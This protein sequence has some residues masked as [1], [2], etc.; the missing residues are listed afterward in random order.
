MKTN[1]ILAALL[2]TTLCAQGADVKEGIYEYDVIS[3]TAV[4]LTKVSLALDKDTVKL[5]VPQTVMLQH[6]EL[7]VTTIGQRAFE[8]LAADSIILPSSITT[9][10]GWAFQNSRKLT[11][12]NL[13]AALEE[14]PA[15]CFAGCTKLSKIV[16][17]EAFTKV[18]NSAFSGCDM[19]ELVFPATLRE[20]GTEAFRQCKS[21]ER[22]VFNGPLD[23]IWYDAFVWCSKLKEVVF[24]GAVKSL[25][26]FAGCS[27]LESVV[28]TEGLQVIESG[29]FRNC[30]AL[31][32][33]TIPQSVR[34]IG[35]S[36][37]AGCTS[38]KEME[39]PAAMPA[40]QMELFQN[41][42]ALERLTIGEGVTSIAG[43]TFDGCTA[44]RHLVVRCQQPPT[45][46][47][48]AFTQE[49]L[50]MFEQAQLEVPTGCKN[51]YATAAFWK[52]FK[53]VTERDMGTC[54]RNMLLNVGEGG[55]VA[56]GQ[57]TVGPEG[58]CVLVPY[59]EEATFSL[60]PDEDH[61]PDLIEVR[62]P[63]HGYHDYTRQVADN[64]FTIGAMPENGELY[65]R[66]TDALVDVDILQTELGV[67]TL[68]VAKN[69]SLR[70][71][72]LPDEG[73]RV[74][75]LTF[76]GK[77]ITEQIQHG[78]YIDTPLL[79]EKS[80]IRIAYEQIGTGVQTLADRQVAVLGDDDGLVVDHLSAGQAVSVYSLDGRLIRSM[81]ATNT[82][83]RIPLTSGQVYIV[84]V[85]RKTIKIRL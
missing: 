22:V 14:I 42:T 18:G 30:T 46:N 67:V 75:S 53:H 78:T 4:K 8:S 20:V 80:T 5:V 19:T 3:P 27:S 73:W 9:I 25:N 29:V 43:S 66:F 59:G 83:Q 37:F 69:H 34:E 62:Y 10:E 23:K 61:A 82:R 1:I 63:Y 51:I 7:T 60:V 16:M 40:M 48:S 72:V 41:C 65:V 38:L 21:L 15:G 50:D 56:Y 54:Y 71:Q 77:D 52:N 17:P 47:S 33:M 64:R 55:A 2:L 68:S 39:L 45:Y 84:K 24:K 85:G 26:G 31:K 35:Q 36:V 13:P 28:L 12:V 81:A 6:R 49:V 74:N 32:E 76:N 11:Y 58:G 79:R 57:W 70:Y 44:L